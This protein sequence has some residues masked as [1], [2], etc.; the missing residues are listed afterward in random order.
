[1]IAHSKQSHFAPSGDP[2]N[3]TQRLFHHLA[4]KEIISAL[5]A[6]SSGIVHWKYGSYD[7][8]SPGFRVVALT[9]DMVSPLEIIPG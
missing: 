7:R 2:D 3:L 5:A 9:K 4:T 6:W 8:I 1:M